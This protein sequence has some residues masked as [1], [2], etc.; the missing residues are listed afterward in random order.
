[1]DAK[2]R[3]LLSGD[4]LRLVAGLS[5]NGAVART[6]IVDELVGYDEE[7]FSDPKYRSNPVKALTKVLRRVVQEAPGVF[8][9]KKRFALCPEAPIREAHAF[10]RD[11]I[12]AAARVLSLGSG[13]KVEWECPGDSCQRSNPARS[14]QIDLLDLPVIEWPEGELFRI[15]FELPRGLLSGDARL[16]K[17]TLRFAAGTDV[18]AA[19]PATMTDPSGVSSSILAA[20]VVDL[21]GRRLSITDAQELSFV[22]RRHLANL[23]EGRTPGVR[24]QAD[25]ECERCGRSVPGHPLSLASFF[26]PA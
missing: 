1:M 9:R 26:S 22:D 10:D 16:C 6:I 17:G 11:L 15:A 4:E 14:T 3:D 25:L 13:F 7:T 24:F 5:S 12:L 19:A 2:F 8:P 20:L 18:E 21:E 23:L